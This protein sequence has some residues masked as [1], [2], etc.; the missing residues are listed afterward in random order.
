[1]S[2]RPTSSPRVTVAIPTYNRAAWLRRCIESVLAQTYDD[3]VLVVSDNAS[4]DETTEVVSSFSDG[5]I[6]YMRHPKNTGLFENHNSCLR[7]VTSEYVLVL[8]DDDLLRPDHLAATVA[9]LDA[10]PD[11]GF[12]HTA[13]DVIGP[14]GQLLTESVDWTYG[15]SGDTVEAGTQFIRES[16]RWSCRV[17]PS[18]ALIRAA[19]IPGLFL[20]EDFP[21]IDF[22]MWLRISLN[23]NVVFLSHPLGCFRVHGTSHS[24]SFDQ[25]VGDSYNHGVGTIT[26]VKGLKQRFLGAHAERLEDV[27]QLSR[28]AE[29]GMRWELV[30]LMH[31]TTVP[32]RSFSSTVRMFRELA[33]VDIRLVVEARAWRLVAASLVG[34]R[35]VDWLKSFRPSS[36]A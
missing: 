14:D 18:T 6:R 20:D 35:T 5:R 19:A 36:G 9:A 34:P 28:L 12:V 17:C 26:G 13:F 3:F 7:R 24:A 32:E 16:M 30:R 1:M 29:A 4:S 25:A 15:L 27:E 31:N 10:H 2:V 23:W 21:A 33:R 8:P 22:G 11:A